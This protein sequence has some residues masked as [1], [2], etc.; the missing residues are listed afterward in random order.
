M[1]TFIGKDFSQNTPQTEEEKE[2]A[3]RSLREASLAIEGTL[4]HFLTVELRWFITFRSGDSF[5]KMN[6]C[7]GP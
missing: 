5:V 7:S 4:R 2:I 1:Q 6:I 3:N